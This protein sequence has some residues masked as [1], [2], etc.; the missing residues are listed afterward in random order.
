MD[1]ALEGPVVFAAPDP[2][3]DGSGSMGLERGLAIRPVYWEPQIPRAA[4]LRLA[5]R[6]I[7]RNSYESAKNE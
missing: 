2:F 6:R 1:E 7:D 3:Q 5:F 4:G